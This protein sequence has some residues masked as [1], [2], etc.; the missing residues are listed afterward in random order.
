MNKDLLQDLINAKEMVK[1]QLK[2]NNVYTVR[3]MAISQNVFSCI[4]KYKNRLLINSE[5]IIVIERLKND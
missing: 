3:G 5:E 2:N 1:I 4:D